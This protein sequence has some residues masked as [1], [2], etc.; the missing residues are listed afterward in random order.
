MEQSI[1]R[2]K[3]QKRQPVY[4]YDEYEDAVVKLIPTD[5]KTMAFLKRRNG[6]EKEL[7][8][9]N[10]IIAD[11]MLSGDEVKESFYYDF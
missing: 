6:K 7:P 11:I 3:L 4:I 8:C 1:L 5:G 2:T 9:G 10:D